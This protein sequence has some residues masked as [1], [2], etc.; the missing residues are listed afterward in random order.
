MELVAVFMLRDVLI[1]LQMEVVVT[2]VKM[3]INTI[4]LLALSVSY[5][6]AH[7]VHQ[8]NN[9]QFVKELECLEQIK[10]HALNLVLQDFKKLVE[11][12]KKLLKLVILT[13]PNP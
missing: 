10:L 5:K 7:T 1:T 11:A 12:V 9:V 3:A 8:K 13:L 4:I 2:L 6:T